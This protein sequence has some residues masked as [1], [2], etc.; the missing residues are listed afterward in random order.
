MNLLSSRFLRAAAVAFALPILG[1]A[2]TATVN[3]TGGTNI[4]NPNGGTTSGTFSE[5]IFVGADIYYLSASY[6]FGSNASGVTVGQFLPT[7]TYIGANPSA[8][9]DTINFDFLG[10]IYDATATSWNGTYTEVIPLSIA[11]GGTGSGELFVDGQG[12]GLVGPFGPG[13]YD[14]SQSATLTGVNGPT[15]GLA[16]D[17]TYTFSAGA[18]DLTTTS[19]PAS[20]ATPEPSTVIP[21]ALGLLGF[22]VMS[23][24]RRKR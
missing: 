3:V 7:V 2:A 14:V 18:P 6:T 1:V 16:Y 20:S 13:S 8:T 10:N 24:R 11:A 23:L 9:A 19:S 12:V 5:S 4:Y 21:A 15:L 22:G 17:F